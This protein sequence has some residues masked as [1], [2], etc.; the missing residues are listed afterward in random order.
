MSRYGNDNNVIWFE[1]EATMGFHAIVH[2]DAKN[3][4]KQIHHFGNGSFSL[5]PIF[6]PRS[7][8][9]QEGDGFLLCYVYRETLNR[10]DLVFLDAQ[11]VDAEPLAIVQLPHQVPFGFHGCSVD[12][13]SLNMTLS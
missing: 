3:N 13:A 11:H 6:V 1:D 2:Y 8:D 4:K 7:S 9:S 10:S 12:S 5:E